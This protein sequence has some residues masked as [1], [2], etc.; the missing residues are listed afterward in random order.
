MMTFD[1]SSA[2]ILSAQIVVIFGHPQVTVLFR[3]PSNSLPQ[4]RHLILIL[5]I[6]YITRSFSVFTYLLHK[7]PDT[8]NAPV[9]V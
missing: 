1:R 3:F 7:M 9:D 2:D 6:F 8:G 4:E 5:S